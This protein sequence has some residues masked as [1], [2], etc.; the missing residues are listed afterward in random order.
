MNA[1]VGRDRRG[2]LVTGAGRG[3]GLATAQALAEDGF[4]VALCDVLPEEGRQAAESLRQA[5]H[6][7]VFVELDVRSSASVAAGVEEAATALGG[8]DVAVNNAGVRAVAA[9]AD[10]SDE[11]WD[12]V[13]DVNLTGVFRCMRAQVPHLL[14]RQGSIIN[15]ASIWGLAGWPTRSAY[16]AAK[17]GVVGLTRSAA[18]EYGAAG[19]RVNAVAPG[20]I[21]TDAA[22]ATVGGT[23]PEME[24]VVGRTAMGRLGRPEEVAGA[25]VWLASAPYVTGEVLAVDGG[26]GA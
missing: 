4:A 15:V 19:L 22:V 24:A 5:G 11:D 17:H 21:G 23:S 2:A 10:L 9:V 12:R 26:W 14:P 1:V 8:L 18:R 7:A 6:T 16:V 25:V 3:I 13:I 20:P